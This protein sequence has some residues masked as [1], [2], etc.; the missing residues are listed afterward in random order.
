MLFVTSHLPYF[1][2]DTYLSRLTPEAQNLFNIGAQNGSY[3]PKSPVNFNRWRPGF[4]ILW[5]G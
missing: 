5:P 2:R 1:F 3:R 4:Y